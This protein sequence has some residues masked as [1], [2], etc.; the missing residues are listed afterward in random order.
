MNTASFCEVFEQACS[1]LFSRIQPFW[2][3]FVYLLVYLSPDFV[4]LRIIRQLGQQ[5]PSAAFSKR[6]RVDGGSGKWKRASIYSF[7]APD[8]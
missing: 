5:W 3:S 8:L 6:G 2:G 4:Y 7:S 1:T